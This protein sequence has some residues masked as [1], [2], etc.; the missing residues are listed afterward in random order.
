MLDLN[1]LQSLIGGQWCL[2]G[3]KPVITG[4]AEIAE[5]GSNDLIYAVDRRRVDLIKDSEC[6]LAILPQGDWDVDCPHICVKNPYLAFA[7]VLE[8][9]N[10]FSPEQVGIS[11]TASIHPD[12]KIGT[13][14]QIY[15]GVVVGRGAKIGDRTILS[16]N[17]SI[18]EDVEIGIDCLVYQNVAVRERCKIGNRVTLQ[19]GCVIGSDGYGFVYEDGVH[20]KIPQLGIVEIGDD[21]ELGA[22]VTVDRGTFRPTI[23]GKG[24]KIDNLV[25]IGHNVILG[26]GCLMASQ[27]G[28]SGTTKVED[29]V[30]FGGQSGSVG[31][32]T[33][34]KGSTIYARG[35]PTQS[36]KPGSKISGFPGRDHKE[37]LRMIA[38]MRKLPNLMKEIRRILKTLN[39]MPG[40]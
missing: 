31:H 30:T 13:D 23:I 39:L 9:L 21:V 32:I 16:S 36:I 35:V 33:I 15:P 5:A 29:Y 28:I 22:N 34:G 20:H 14:V 1:K 27:S 7:R 6:G 2:Q 10:N 11:P 17:T 3:K 37:D 26:E 18:G 12:S 19:P 40:S 38:T 24:S 8:L 25:Q 4:V